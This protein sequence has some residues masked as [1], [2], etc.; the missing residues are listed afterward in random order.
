[1]KN[2]KVKIS[3]ALIP[4]AIIIM[5]VYI[6]QPDI[7]NHVNHRQE[8]KDLKVIGNTIKAYFTQTELNKYPQNPRDFGFAPQTL[9]ILHVPSNWAD[10]N[11]IS[12]FD[13]ISKSERLYRKHK[14]VILFVSKSLSSRGTK[15]ALFEDG[16]IE[17]LSTHELQT[18]LHQ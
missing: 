5:L 15:V 18:F 4:C 12:L 11:E 3:K 1:M 13:Y 16:H 9:G 6:L 14:R 17:H 2:I 7:M 8:E 10:F